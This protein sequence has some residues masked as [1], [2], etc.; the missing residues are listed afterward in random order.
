MKEKVS[1]TRID[2]ILEYP[3][4]GQLFVSGNPAGLVTARGTRAR[5]P[6]PTHVK[7]T[8]TLFFMILWSY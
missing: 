7:Y 6:A 1:F 3:A 8:K 2:A 4:L 5:Y